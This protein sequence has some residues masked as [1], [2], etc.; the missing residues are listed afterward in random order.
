MF[1]II[2]FSQKTNSSTRNFIEGADFTQITKDWNVTADFRSGIGEEVSYFPVVATNLKTNEKINALQMDMDIKYEF[3]GKSRSY[4][5]SS[6]IDLDE[7][8]E[9]IYF[10]EN[11][12]I[13]NLKDKTDK[14]QSNTYIFS[15]KEMTFKFHIEKNSRRISI[16]LKDFGVVDNEHYFWT[17]SQVDKI[18]QLIEM[19]KKIK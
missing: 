7:I 12:V 17:E 1:P 8:G 16:Y 15:S 2:V 5:K 13:P 11:Y 9:F 3:M 6:W 14:K 18:P 10:L 4:F 19:L